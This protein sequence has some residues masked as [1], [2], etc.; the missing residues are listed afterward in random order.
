M[1]TPKPFRYLARRWPFLRWPSP[2]RTQEICDVGRGVCRDFRAIPFKH[3]ASIYIKRK[4]FAGPG[5]IHG[6]HLPSHDGEAVDVARVG[7]A[8]G[9][10]HLGTRRKWI[11]RR[12]KNR[13]ADVR[14]RNILGFSIDT[15]SGQG[16]GMHRRLRHM[17]GSA[18]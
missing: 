3:H 7:A 4:I 18:E 5:K 2:A 8:P 6:K 13:E 15:G 10:K 9:V 17:Y 16:H 14:L 1:A 11:R 12:I